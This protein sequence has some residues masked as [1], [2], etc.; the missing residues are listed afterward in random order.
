M[1]DA[2]LTCPESRVLASGCVR[3]SDYYL[4][5]LNT[6]WDGEHSHCWL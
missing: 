2:T 3:G 5:H 4:L 6:E 1:Y